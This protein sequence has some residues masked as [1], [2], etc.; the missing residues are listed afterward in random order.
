MVRVAILPTPSAKEAPLRQTGLLCLNQGFVASLVAQTVAMFRRGRRTH[1]QRRRW[2]LVRTELWRGRWLIAGAGAWLV[3][4][5]LVVLVVPFGPTSFRAFVAGSLV[6]SW[7]W[8]IYV[9][10][11]LRTYPATMGEWGESFTRELLAR[12][13]FG[14]HVVHDVPLEHRN[15]DHVAISPRAV[16]AIETKFLGAGRRWST[17]RYGQAALDDAFSGARSVRSILRSQG[18]TNVPVEP[19][20][21][22]WGPGA[23]QFSSGWVAVGEVQVVQGAA[24]A[25]GWRHHNSQGEI[26]TNLAIAAQDSLLR[27]REMRDSAC[28]ERP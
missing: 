10:S 14:W 27:H 17:D 24:T 20:L 21:M 28:T 22:L 5:A 12:R 6:T 19:V 1:E 16:L 18:I 4:A 11:I 3:G 8:M 2:G 23:P 13:E 25:D 7:G 26:S 15:V 9:T